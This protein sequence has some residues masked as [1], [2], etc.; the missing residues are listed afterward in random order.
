MVLAEPPDQGLFQRADLGPQ[1]SQR[2]FSKHL[3]ITLPGGQ[4]RQHRPGRLT[5]DVADHMSVCRLVRWFVRVMC[6]C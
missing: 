1:T 2:Q 5:Q 3:G 4:R 6:E